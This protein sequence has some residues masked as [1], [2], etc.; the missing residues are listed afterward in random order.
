M[1][2]PIRAVRQ[3]KNL[4]K[5]GKIDHFRK[6]CRSKTE[7]VNKV[8]KKEEFNTKLIYKEIIINKKIVNFATTRDLHAHF[9]IK[10]LLLKN[11]IRTLKSARRN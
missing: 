5:C 7:K 2:H 10:V 9:L 8:K 4:R 6:A 3:R 11:T 1:L